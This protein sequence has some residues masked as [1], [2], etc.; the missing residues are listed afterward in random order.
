MFNDQVIQAFFNVPQA[1]ASSQ[2]FL[3]QCDAVDHQ[4]K[5]AAFGAFVVNIICNHQ[6]VGTSNK[7]FICE[8]QTFAE[9]A[10]QAIENDLLE[11]DA[12]GLYQPV[13]SI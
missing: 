9:I 11:F 12:S 2:E 5:L 3:Q 6:N 13:L 8:E 4:Q 1:M 7:E 10:T